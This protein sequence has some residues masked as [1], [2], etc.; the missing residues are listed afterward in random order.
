MSILNIN[1]GVSHVG[2]EIS[3]S[4]MNSTI[5]RKLAM[6]IDLRIKAES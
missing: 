3:P 5:V 2:N 4:D 1:V 6:M